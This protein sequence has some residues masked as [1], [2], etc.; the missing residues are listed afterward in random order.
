MSRARSACSDGTLM[1]GTAGYARLNG[2]T[3]F[4]IVAF[5]QSARLVGIVST[6]GGPR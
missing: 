4:G 5:Y 2:Q 6:E 3:T 1:D